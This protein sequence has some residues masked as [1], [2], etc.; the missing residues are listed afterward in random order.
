M[1]ESDHAAAAR[2]VLGWL[3]EAQAPGPGPQVH[4]LMGFMR[5][6]FVHAFRWAQ[7]FSRLQTS[8]GWSIGWGLTPC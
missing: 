4:K 3:Q 2:T 8:T 5:W 1:Q 7:L 6:G